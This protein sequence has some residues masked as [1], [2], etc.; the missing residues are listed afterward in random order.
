MQHYNNTGRWVVPFR[1]V[2][3]P[4]S[5]T[6]ICGSMKRTVGYC[7]TLPAYPLCVDQGRFSAAPVTLV[8]LV[9]SIFS[10]AFC[11]KHVCQHTDKQ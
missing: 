11:F 7:D 4:A 5:D 1:A 10:D 6:I 8:L 9:L 2:W 3:G